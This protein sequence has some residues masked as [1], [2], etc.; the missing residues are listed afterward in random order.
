M[1]IKIT[2]MINIT[3]Y[4]IIFIKDQIEYYNSLAI[5]NGDELLLC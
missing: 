3:L 2:T 5:N 4:F 1:N